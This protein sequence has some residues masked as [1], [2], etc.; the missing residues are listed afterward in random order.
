[1]LTAFNEVIRFLLEVAGL[2]AL[3]F[4]GYRSVEGPMRFVTTAAAPALVI[5]VWARWIAPRA[6]TRLSQVARLWLGTGILM[7]TAVTLALV[8]ERALALTMGL[9]VLANSTMLHSRR[10]VG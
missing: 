2:Y 7:G 9:L 5:L 1:M 10:A 3:G 8:E 4:S 6:R